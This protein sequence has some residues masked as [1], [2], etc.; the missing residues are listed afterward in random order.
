MIRSPSLAYLAALT[1]LVACGQDG[2][3]EQ[4]SDP[5]VAAIELLTRFAFA[6]AATIR[7]RF[8]DGVDPENMPIRLLVDRPEEYVYEDLWRLRMID[9]RAVVTALVQIRDEPRLFDLW[10]EARGESWQVA[11]WSQTLRPVRVEDAVAIAGDPVPAAMAKATF[12]D[13]HAVPRLPIGDDSF[14]EGPQAPPRVRVGYKS[15]NHRGRCNAEHIRTNLRQRTE[16]LRLCYESALSADD[17]RI[18]RLTVE[19]QMR[20]GRAT[21]ETSI[22]ETTLIVNALTACAEEVL[23]QLPGQDEGECVIRVPMTFTPFEP[24]REPKSRARTKKH[25]RQ[26]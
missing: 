10:F 22:A 15:L 26:K 6:P 1:G 20:A 11:G 4:V 17:A 9:G 8:V 3:V 25:R 5:E 18:G 13:V 7:P 19:V 23:S 16:A 24:P 2:T 21:H 12:R 14:A